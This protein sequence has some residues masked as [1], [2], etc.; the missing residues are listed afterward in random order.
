LRHSIDS[1]Y[2]CSRRRPASA[3]SRARDLLGN[4]GAQ[5]EV[6]VEPDPEQSGVPEVDAAMLT[7]HDPVESMTMHRWMS[8]WAELGLKEK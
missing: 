5:S 8:R 6:D 1:G 3:Q 4:H 2:D 7:F